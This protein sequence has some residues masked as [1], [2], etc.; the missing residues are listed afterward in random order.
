MRGAFIAAALV[1]VLAGT[2][3]AYI[4]DKKFELAEARLLESIRA[5]VRTGDETPETG[6]IFELFSKSRGCKLAI[7]EVLR[8]YWVI[9]EGPSL[10][11]LIWHELSRHVD[12]HDFY[13]RHGIE[14]G[15]EAP[16]A[17]YK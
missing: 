1:L 14:N 5:E 6:R 11:T 8:R 12:D 2:A 3:S 15:C 10:D 7:R 4:T 13:L 17:Y 16:L 9:L